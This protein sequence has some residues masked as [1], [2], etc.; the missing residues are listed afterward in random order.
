MDH[1]IRQ[2]AD[3]PVNNT[4]ANH[5]KRTEKRLDSL[6]FRIKDKSDRAT[7]EQVLDPRTIRILSKIINRENSPIS[8]I[9]GCVSTGK[10]ANVYH[11]TSVDGKDRVIKIYKTS[12]LVFRD[13]DKYVQGEF[14]FRRGYCKGNPRK[15]VQT[16]AE[17]EYRNL[18]RLRAAALPCPEPHYLKNHILIMDMIGK[19]GLPAPLLKNATFDSEINAAI[20]TARSE[21]SD[22][23]N[24]DSN[25]IAADTVSS[26][27]SSLYLKLL[28]IMRRM[29]HECRLV[30]ADLSEF[31][32]LYMDGEIYIIDVSQS[33]EHDHVMALEFLRKDCYNVND[34]F[35]KRGIPTLTTRELFDFITDPNITKDNINEYLNRLNEIASSRTMEA[36]S[37]QE[38]I[39]EEVFKSA[40]IPKRLDDVIDFEKDVAMAKEMGN[41]ASRDLL[42]PTLTGMKSDLSGARL[43]PGLLEETTEK[44]QNLHI[45]ESEDD[46]DDA[47]YATT[48]GGSDES[49]EESSGGDE[50]DGDQSNE[51]TTEDNN[52]RRFNSSARPKDEDAEAKR[53]RKKAIK[54]AQRHKRENKKVP[55]HVKKRRAKLASERK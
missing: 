34:Y 49:S 12:I 10:E 32:M 30:H 15:M 7:V 35:R 55:K 16:W 29:F 38:K 19:D 2:D 27:Y 24:I 26:I 5:L 52:R 8:E 20:E 43:K 44:I 51:E 17:K 37:E 31:N 9:H 3:Y 6:R 13:R 47:P 46:S 1:R 39:D 50:T 28:V 18:L 22:D 25:A 21:S 4:T 53:K 45:K 41:E 23:T 33:V 48:S 54:L 36:L 42:Y 11:A 40:Y 14:R